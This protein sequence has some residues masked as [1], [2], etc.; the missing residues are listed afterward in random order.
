MCLKP[1]CV[2]VDLSSVIAWY[3]PE[4]YS[5]L[6]FIN[7]YGEKMSLPLYIQSVTEVCYH[8]VCIM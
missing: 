8:G 6:N 4:N 1:L 3:I 5:D 7:I 2:N